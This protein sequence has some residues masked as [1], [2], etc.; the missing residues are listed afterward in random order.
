MSSGAVPD[1]VTLFFPQKR[2]EFLTIVLKNDDL[3]HRPTPT[4]TTRTGGRLSGF[5]EI[6]SQ[7]Y[8]DF[9]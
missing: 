8:L 9:H 3:Y 4:V 5:L 6:H 2:D 7:K 1:G